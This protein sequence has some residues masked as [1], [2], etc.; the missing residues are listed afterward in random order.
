GHR[1]PSTYDYVDNFVGISSVLGDKSRR[2]SSSIH[3]GQPPNFRY[4]RRMNPRLFCPTKHMQVSG[5]TVI[6]LR[7]GD[8]VTTYRA[9][10]YV[11]FSQHP[12]RAHQHEARLSTF[13]SSQLR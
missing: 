9:M 1:A 10:E 12:I 13:R 11:I 6:R 8:G 3:H 2:C 5:D 7:A 4:R